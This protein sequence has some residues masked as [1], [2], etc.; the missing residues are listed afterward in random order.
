ME[1]R[2]P[3]LKWWPVILAVV[4]VIGAFAKL[5]SDVSNLKERVAMLETRVDPL[6]Q[7]KVSKGD[8]CLKILE[9]WAK[10]KDDKRQRSLWN[11]WANADCESVPASATF[12]RGFWDQ[13]KNSIAV[14]P[15]P[16]ESQPKK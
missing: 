14:L 13:V 16:L 2:Y 9:E 8:L 12:T 7:L 4:A 10:L 15:P 3:I 1:D 6:R 11:Q 5:Q